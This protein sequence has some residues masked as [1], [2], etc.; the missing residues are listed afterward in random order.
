MHILDTD[1]LTHL[2]KKNSTAIENLKKVEA[3]DAI[4]ITIVTR[5]EVLKGRID[6]LFKASDKAQLEKAQRLLSDSEDFLAQWPV[7]WS[8]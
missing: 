8:L 3:H 5:A 7:I 2:Q 1:T 4:A 6:F